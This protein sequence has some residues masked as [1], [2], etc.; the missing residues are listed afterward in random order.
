ML[1]LIRRVE[2]Y[3]FIGTKKNE[4]LCSFGFVYFHL[5]SQTTLLINVVGGYNLQY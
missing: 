1:D 4:N 2:N 3:V 5:S